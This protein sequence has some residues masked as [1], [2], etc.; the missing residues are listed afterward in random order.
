MSSKIAIQGYPGSFHQLAARKYFGKQAN[1]LLFCQTFVDVFNSLET[2]QAG[3][4]LVAIGNN[5]YGDID[6]VYDILIENRLAKNRP[7]YWIS[8]EV[9]I[10]I[11]H[12]LLG[13]K[14]ATTA[15]IKEVYS[16]AP[17][18]VQCFGFVHNNLAGAVA[19]EEDDTA[20]SARFVSEAGDKSKAAIASEE[21]AKLYN[22]K[23]LAKGIED[24]TNNIT[25][26]LIIE[27]RRVQKLKGTSKTS[28]L[29]RTSH[30]PGALVQALN[31]FSDNQINISYLQSVP[32]PNRPFEYRFY[33]DIDGGL[34]DKKVS[35]ALEG[36]DNLGYRYD[37]L[38]SY[39]K[40]AVPKI[41]S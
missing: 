33:I 25:R 31:L 21:A 10:N 32:I 41:K 13:L 3:R 40:A 19:I 22:L 11:V 14:G 20:L 7:K 29:L 23:V 5:R 39:K 18:I 35:K 28:M 2:G 15:D 17:A 12:C 27:P 34:E 1:D 6:H 26:F 24:D 30:K 37:V 4:A 16:Q 9:Y 38:G 8:G 36:L